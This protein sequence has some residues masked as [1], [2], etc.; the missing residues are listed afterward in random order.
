MFSYKRESYIS[1][2]ENIRLMNFVERYDIDTHTHEFFELVYTREGSGIHTVDGVDYPVGHGDLVFIGRRQTHAY[3]PKGSMHMVNILI[4]P[5]FI[6]REL[7][8][9]ESILLLFLHSM[10]SEFEEA[11]CPS[12][13]CVHFSGEERDEVDAVI[14]MLVREYEGKAVGY[15]AML[16]GAVR[17]LFAKILRRLGEREAMRDAGFLDDLE[18]YIN[19]HLGDKIS[20]TELATR[21]FYNPVYFGSL[22]KKYSGKSFSTYLREK[23][24]ARAAEL[25][26]DPSLSVDDVIARVGYGNRNVFYSH[27]AE[28]F[29]MTPGAYRK[30]F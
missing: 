9:T 27:F 28:R 7:V 23:R 20:L 4:T 5:E 13:Q 14:A 8:D 3:R 21:S 18:R 19:E 17:I 1:E 11:P 12:C 15:R 24:L 16:Q 29:G 2:D 6:S 30:T 25:L 22:I 26:R 10:T